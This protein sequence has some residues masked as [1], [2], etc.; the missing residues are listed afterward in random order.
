ME[1][2]FFTAWV[3]IVGVT[4]IASLVLRI[5]QMKQKKEMDAA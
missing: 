5:I 2:T 1:E 3:I 4:R